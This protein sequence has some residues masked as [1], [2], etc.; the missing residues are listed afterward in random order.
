MIESLENILV[1]NFSQFLINR[2]IASR[3]NPKSVKK[4]RNRNILVAVNEKNQTKNIITS[5]RLTNMTNQTLLN[6]IVSPEKIDLKDWKKW[7]SNFTPN[8]N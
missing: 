4:L 5:I 8:K 3:S 2:E 6:Q 7:T 1:S